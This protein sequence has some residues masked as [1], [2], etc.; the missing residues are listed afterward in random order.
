VAEVGAGG[1]VEVAWLSGKECPYLEEREP[2]VGMVFVRVCAGT[3]VMGSKEGDE[4]AG[5][6]EKPAHRVR[7]GEFWIGK[8]EV[9]NEEYRRWRAGHQKDEPADWPATNV[10][11]EEARDYCQWLGGRLPTEAE[12]EYAARGADGRKYPWGN[13]AP[14]GERAV[15]SNRWGEKSS[16]EPVTSHPRG[17]GPFGTLHQAGNVW[18]WVQDC[19][20]RYKAGQEIDNPVSDKPGC[21]IRVV[22]GGSFLLEPRSLRSALRD[23]GEPG[24]RYWHFGFRC[25][26]A[27][28]RQP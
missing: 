25:V 2:R 16:P 12:W 20:E 13:E 23:W 14:D 22:R 6:N 8:H 5:S 26:R 7:V 19:Y 4:E 21:E 27:S 24:V 17:M 15:F 3:F 18:E 1:E 11:W 10:T 9:S 28:G